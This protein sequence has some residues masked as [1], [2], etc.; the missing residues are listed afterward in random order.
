MLHKKVFIPSPW[1]SGIYLHPQ[2]SAGSVFLPSQK[3][4]QWLTARPLANF[5]KGG[6]NFRCPT[7]NNTILFS[8]TKKIAQPK[9]KQ[10]T[11]TRNIPQ[12][13]DKKRR[14]H[15]PPRDKVFASSD[16]GDSGGVD[17]VKGLVGLAGWR[18]DA[19][20]AALSTSMA[21]ER[22]LLLKL[23]LPQSTL[24]KCS[25]DPVARV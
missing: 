14:H 5:G 24:P 18:G 15:Y 23:L 3:H 6:R 13:Y 22:S 7:N 25:C 8:D 19:V 2:S 10:I 4:G 16:V 12:W 17:R 21:A 20:L 11:I 1:S 9:S